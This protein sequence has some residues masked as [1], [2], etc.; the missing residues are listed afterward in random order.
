MDGDDKIGGLVG[1]NKNNETDPGKDS[2]NKT[3]AVGNVSGNS[4]VGGLVGQD[5]YDNISNSYWDN[6]TT[7]QT[8]TLNG[9]TGL[10][11]SEMT[12]DDA[13]TNMS[14][15]NFETIW[16]TRTGDYP[17]LITQLTETAAGGV[18]GPSDQ[19]IKAPEDFTYHPD[20]NLTIGTSHNATGV[21]SDG[22]VEIRMVNVTAGNNTVVAVNDSAS[23]PV[24]GDVNTTID[25]ANLSGD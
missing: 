23:I 12:G 5:D 1:W 16:E 7:G 22:D 14:G 2:I 3:F 6:Q 20:F 19:F 4:N 15:L 17:A 24:E 11:T 18:G 10:T 9:A 8:G 25:A 21:I 13:P